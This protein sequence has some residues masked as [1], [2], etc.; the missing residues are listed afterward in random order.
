M[1]RPRLTTQLHKMDPEQR[2]KYVMQLIRK[3]D[4]LKDELEAAKNDRAAAQADLAEA[5]KRIK[6]AEARVQ[7]A[8]TGLTHIEASLQDFDLQ[9]LFDKDAVP[10]KPAIGWTRRKQLR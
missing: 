6:S 5:Q 9:E 1:D 3:R 2:G 10:D 8:E 4:R 7:E